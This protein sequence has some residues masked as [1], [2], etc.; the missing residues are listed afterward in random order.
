MDKFIGNSDSEEEQQA[1]KLHDLESDEEFY[2]FQNNLDSDE[3]DELIE[4]KQKKKTVDV[5]DKEDANED[6]DDAVDEEKDEQKDTAMSDESKTNKEEEDNRNELFRKSKLAKLKSKSKPKGKT[7]VVYLSK[8]PPYMKPAKMRQILSRFGEVDRLFLKKEDST[9]YKKRVKYGGNKKDMYEEGWAEFIK[10]RDAKI[11]AET[12]NGNIL[13]GKKGNYYHDDIMNVKYLSGFK[14]NDLT[15]Q[16]SREH[17]SREAKLHIEVEQSKKLNK[18]FIA[19]V[20]KS[21]MIKNIK[22]KKAEQQ[23]EPAPTD[24]EIRRTFEQRKVNSIRADGPKEYKTK[25]NA[26]LD[27]VL[28]SVF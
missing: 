28:S 11:C 9:K 4:T 2:S 16:I 13:G 10:K 5:F 19:N 7:G 23:G 20:E 27:S 6:E 25:N 21:K 26:K 12:L 15:D 8:I 14:W 22:S 24:V 17:E 1:S 18:T 3:E